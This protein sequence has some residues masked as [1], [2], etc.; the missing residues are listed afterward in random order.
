VFERN[1][2]DANEEVCDGHDVVIASVAQEEFPLLAG[3]LLSCSKYK[4]SFCDWGIK[5][6]MTVCPVL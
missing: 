2:Y 6:G 3:D 4:P 5:F 1:E